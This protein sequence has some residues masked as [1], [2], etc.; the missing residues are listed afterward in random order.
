MSSSLSSLSFC[1][2]PSNSF[3]PL[4]CGGLWEAVTTAPTSSASSA[5]AGLGSTPPS[6][7]E[8]PAD[9]IP[10]PSASSSSTPDARV[11]RPTK[12]RPRPDQSATALPSLSTS[13]GVSVS[14]TIPRTPS[15]P[16]YLR[17][18]GARSLRDSGGR[19]R[20]STNV[21]AW[22]EIP[23]SP[24]KIDHQSAETARSAA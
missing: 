15:V 11:S 3:T 20:S 22:V 10:R 17:A 13:P 6:T 21:M 7:A 14:P 5:T 23:T 24:K 12:T 4:Y 1:P 9:A 16:K 18:I 8:P 2:S 19:S